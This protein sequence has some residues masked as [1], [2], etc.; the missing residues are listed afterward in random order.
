MIYMDLFNVKT[1]ENDEEYLRQVS[2]DVIK[3]DP[4][5]KEELKMLSSYCR[6]NEVFAM[7]AVQLGIPKKI[8]YI[9][10][11]DEKASYGID[12]VDDEAIIMINPKI[13]SETGETYFWEN[14]VSCMDNTGKVKRPYQIK[15]KYYDENFEEKEETFEGLKATIFSHEYDHLHGILHMDIAEEIKHMNVDERIAFRK[16]DGNGYVVLSKTKEYKHPL[17]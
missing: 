9:K 4:K 7:A 17:R 5:L 1:I 15:V 8:I 13:I 3:G 2:K 14:C 6:D 12:I 11:T 10:T 16:K